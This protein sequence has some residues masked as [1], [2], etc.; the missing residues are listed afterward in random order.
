[1][2]LFSS[3]KRIREIQNV[4]LRLANNHCSEFQ[5][6]HE[7][8][9]LAGRVQAVFVSLVTPVRNGRPCVENTFAAITK[10]LSSSGLSL[11]LGE[12]RALDEVILGFRWDATDMKFVRAKARHV[13][14]LGAGFY[15]LGLK[16]LEVVPTGDFPELATLRF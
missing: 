4:L 3:N 8:P 2:L 1:M 7:G 15:Q 13:A 14:P 6:V 10:E 5:A 16:C 11:V 9:R 12:P